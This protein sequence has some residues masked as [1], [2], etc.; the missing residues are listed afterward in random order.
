V[1]GNTGTEAIVY[2]ILSKKQ[3]APNIHLLKIEAPAVANKARAGHF[4]VL[5]VDERGERVPMTI[6]DWDKNE[7]SISI[8]FVPVG[9]STAKLEALAAG[10]LIHNVSGPL[11]VPTHIEKFGTVVCVGGCYGIAS[12]M[13][14]ARA[15]K[16]AGNKVIS[17]IEGRS[18]NLLYWEDK[19]RSVSD[20]LI[21]AAGDYSYS[22]K[23]WIPEKMAEIMA[24][25]KVDIVVAVGCT[26]MMMRCSEITRP[27]AIKTVVHLNPIM[28]DGT[29]MC[30]CCR[31]S[32]GGETKFACVH[33]P[34]FDGHRVDWEL[35]AARQRAYL[36]EE[37]YSLQVWECRNWQKHIG[38]TNGK[39]DSKPRAD[40]P[41]RA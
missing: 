14:I 27:S 5:R 34:E 13:P 6:A 17:L 36:D 2:R 22:E 11:G 20:R 39:V 35:L 28:V 19:L 15:M 3:L 4:V 37:V 33:G 9:T 38:K 25:G 8:V 12:I 41:A 1:K 24:G 32:V 10:D 40:A 29:G 21:T 16:E 18:G 26:Y 31:V 7:G 30:G 23:G